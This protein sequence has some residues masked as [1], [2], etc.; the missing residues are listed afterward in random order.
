[1][2]EPVPQDEWDSASSD[3]SESI[4]EKLF[5]PRLKHFDTSHPAFKSAFLVLC[6]QVWIYSVYSFASS[7]FF[8]FRLQAARWILDSVFQPWLRLPIIGTY[9]LTAVGLWGVATREHEYMSDFDRA[10]SIRIRPGLRDFII[11]VSTSISYMSGIAFFNR[12]AKVYWNVLGRMK[13]FIS[14]TYVLPFGITAL[15]VMVVPSWKSIA[16]SAV[17]QIHMLLNKLVILPMF[18]LRPSAW[19]LGNF[20]TA[21][22][23]CRSRL[24]LQLSRRIIKSGSLK[25]ESYAYKPIDGGANEFRVLKIRTGLFDTRCSVLSVSAL[26]G[27]IP[28]YET[29]SWTWD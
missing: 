17:R 5:T 7:I 28:I 15:S 2:E 27:P 11:L 13:S 8:P 4:L 14:S 18:I 24:R 10:N 22:E 29:L 6:E 1:M 16:S 3:N 12:H 25:E 21:T 19:L 26:E 20:L 9:S 23:Y